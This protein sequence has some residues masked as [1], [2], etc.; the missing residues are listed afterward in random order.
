MMDFKNAI[1]S[2][3]KLN[4][5][6]SSLPR[7]IPHIR[8]L[9]MYF[10]VQEVFIMYLTGEECKYQILKTC[11]CKGFAKQLMP[12]SLEEGGGGGCVD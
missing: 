2:C 5:K 3:Q 9:V 4:K 11:V 12:W 6:K 10:L 1:K 8:S 7:I